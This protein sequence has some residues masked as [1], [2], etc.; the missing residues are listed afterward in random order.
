MIQNLIFVNPIT[1]QTNTIN[2]NYP[3]VDY[4]YIGE[5]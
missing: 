5:V 3:D 2:I 1:N 4:I